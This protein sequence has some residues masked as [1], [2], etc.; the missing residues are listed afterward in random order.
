M[1]PCVADLPVELAERCEVR[2]GGAL[3][4]GPYVLYWMR[5]ALRGHENPALDVA[6]SWAR[7]ARCPV[8][9]YHGL[10]ERYPFAS[11]RHHTFILEGA[12]DVAAELAERGVPY[13]LHVEREGQRGP[14]LRTLASRAVGV[15]TEE[16]PVAPLRG[17]TERLASSVDVPFVTVDTACVL[18]MRLVPEAHE[19]AFAFRRKTQRARGERLRR[20][21]DDVEPA[22]RATL[23]DVDVTLP[24]E[25]VDLGAQ[26]IDELVAACAIDHAVGPVPHTR[27][28]SVA[29]YARWDAFV[30]SKGLA[31]YARDRNDPLRDGVSRMSAYFH[32]GM[33]SPLRIA[34]DCAT[35]GG[36]GAE[37]YLDELLIWR[38]V[39]HAFC[40]HRDDVDTLASLPEWAQLTLADHA[41]DPRPEVY[42]RDVLSRGATGDVLWDATQRSLLVHGELHN[43]LRMTW[44]K[45][46]VPWTATPARALELLL[47]LNHRYA[48][49]GRDPAS[50][51]GLLWC[52]GGF[53]RPFD[54]ERAVTGRLRERTTREHG[55]RLDVDA[56]A[57]RVARPAADERRVAVIGA[58][59]VGLTAARTLVDH[60]HDV[61]V[62]EARDVLGGDMATRHV[63][64][65]AF[66]VAAPL[67]DAPHEALAARLVESWLEGGL[68]V[69]RD[70]QL[71]ASPSHEALVDDL[72]RDVDLRLARRVLGVER[73]AGGWALRV[74][75]ADLVGFDAAVV[76]TGFDDA[77]ALLAGLPPCAT[78][79][80][81]PTHATT[82][83]GL[84]RA[85]PFADARTTV[86]RGIVTVHPGGHEGPLD[87]WVV[88]AAD[89]GLDDDTCIERAHAR[90]GGGASPDVARVWRR[91]DVVAPLVDLDDGLVT[92]LA[93]ARWTLGVDTGAAAAGRL[94]GLFA[95]A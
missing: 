47:D 8:L 81:A 89:D 64:G 73:G 83:V 20:A 56:Y 28:G 31:R 79:A 52:L 65:V 26:P 77:R 42:T 21:W 19:R 32:H 2:R 59:V 82:C 88:H 14:H 15:V 13:V 23:G 85:E 49:D 12:R 91:R 5:A 71:V 90:V 39:A 30:A 44:G 6:L 70:G 1:D 58:G 53:D 63:D 35:R 27:G 24:F 9:V 41:D 93:P 78:L 4:S 37:K 43:N 94:L 95:R 51:G 67:V 40:F 7:Q 87:A 55:K 48:L 84:A 74:D 16:A 68:L 61:Q 38:E 80:D 3:E 25:P 66:D 11:D 72:A 17:W 29:G 18:P 54:P 62:F 46:L 92:A 69:E 33:V 50:Y 22:S 60:G 86:E 36:P 57:R 45:A 10:S 34:R 76:A 75:D